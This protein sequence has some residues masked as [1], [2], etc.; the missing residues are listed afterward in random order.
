MIYRLLFFRMW[1]LVFGLGLVGSAYA[2]SGQ[3]LLNEAQQAL[4]NVTI[5]AAAVSQA[6]ATGTPERVYVIG[7]TRD[8]NAFAKLNDKAAQAIGT[9]T[10]AGKQAVAFVAEVKPDFSDYLHVYFMFGKATVTDRIDALTVS[11]DGTRV[12]IGGSTLD[13]SLPDTQTSA[14]SY[15]DLGEGLQ[16]FL[17]R[18]SADLQPQLSF[19]PVTKRELG[20]KRA[21]CKRHYNGVGCFIICAVPT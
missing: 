2:A 16:A 4:A 15:P 20:L 17:T 1:V 7:Y 13:R 12:Y 21:C 14:P 11:A 6:T 9:P 10:F 18:F 3:A 5:T 8:A 19:Y